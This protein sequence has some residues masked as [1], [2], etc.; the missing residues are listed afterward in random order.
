MSNRP[1]NGENTDGRQGSKAK[2]NNWLPIV[3][4]ISILSIIVTN[5]FAITFILTKGSLDSSGIESSLLSTG[6]SIIG[7]AIAVWAGLNI[8][9][10]ISRSEIN[11]LDVAV[12]GLK[13][14]TES[15]DKDIEKI[16]PFV[17]ENK[18]IL[19]QLFLLELERS[20]NDPIAY[21]LA[22]K[23]RRLNLQD[24][25]LPYTKLIEIELIYS[26]M[27][28]RHQSGYDYDVLLIQLADSGINKI[29]EIQEVYIGN[30]HNKKIFALYL[31]Y[32]EGGFLF[33]KGYC[34]KTKVI[35]AQ[36][37]FDAAGKFVI[38]KDEFC[39]NDQRAVIHEMAYID[40]SIGESYSKITHYYTDIFLNQ[41]E[42]SKKDFIKLL[43]DKKE[44]IEDIAES[45]VY[46]CKEAT[47]S[48]LEHS[49]LTTYFRNLGC[50]YERQDRVE[51]V[52]NKLKNVFY[53]NEEI[54]KNYKESFN[55]TINNH[56]IN[57]ASSR[58]AY[59]TLLSYYNKYIDYLFNNGMEETDKLADSIN[60]MYAISSLAI[61][62]HTRSSS[63]YALYGFACYYV[64]KAQKIQ[65]IKKMDKNILKKE[66]DR[67]SVV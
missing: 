10:L 15:L 61:L 34:A 5:I 20:I 14:D 46:Y 3:V 1:D 53:Q 65:S 36:Y 40:N 13:A 39:S 7:I 58:N 12:N 26:Q 43:A 63:L 42:Q 37:F 52:K 38:V 56:Q 11:E 48:K 29:K 17:D 18:N 50:A 19:S 51:A 32:R 21:Y 27:Y 31:N 49:V 59:Y 2:V 44:E 35:G 60:N 41:E 25:C 67:K 24:I 57:E 30:E 16:R 9:N 45:A 22:E 4:V 66:I 33:L 6:I 28:S 23:I 64:F 8:S 55:L 47:K 54:I 62:D